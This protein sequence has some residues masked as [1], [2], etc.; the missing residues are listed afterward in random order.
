MR[1]YLSHLLVA[2]LVVALFSTAYLYWMRVRIRLLISHPIDSPFAT[3]PRPYP[4]PDRWLEAWAQRWHGS[5]SQGNPDYAGPGGWDLVRERIDLLLYFAVLVSLLCLIGV[6]ILYLRRRR[7]E[8]VPAG[9]CVCDS[10]GYDLHGIEDSRCPEC[11]EG[12]TPSPP[13]VN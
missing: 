3:S 6:A 2:L 7:R 13:T 4:Y 5:V 8:L 10:C 9:H 12:F 11:G 1:R